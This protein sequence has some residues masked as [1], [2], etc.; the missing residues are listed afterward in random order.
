MCSTIDF[1]LG[2]KIQLLAILSKRIPFKRYFPNFVKLFYHAY[3]I[4]SHKSNKSD[5]YKVDGVSHKISFW[6]LLMKLKK[7]NS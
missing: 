7:N 2:S 4:L 3:F 5:T 1:W 6:Q